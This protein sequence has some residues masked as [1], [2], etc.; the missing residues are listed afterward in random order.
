MFIRGD[1]SQEIAFPGRET[2]F[3]GLDRE[4][5]FRQST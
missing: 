5:R 4:S 3:P 1:N 2:Q